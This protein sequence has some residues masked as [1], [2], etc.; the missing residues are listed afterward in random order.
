MNADNKAN[1]IM[2]QITNGNHTDAYD[3]IKRADKKT[4]LHWVLF[5]INDGWR[6]EE[7]ERYFY[8]AVRK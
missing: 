5:C 2:D 6:H 3:L 4:I 1:A 8:R 7:I